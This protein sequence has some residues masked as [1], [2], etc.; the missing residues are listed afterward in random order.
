MTNNANRKELVI[1]NI[2]VTAMPPTNSVLG[3][4][5][6]A[7]GKNANTVVAVAAANGTHK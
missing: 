1:E 3:P 6:L 7:I 2:T 5:P 4:L